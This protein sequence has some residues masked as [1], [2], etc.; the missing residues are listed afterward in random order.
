MLEKKKE[1]LWAGGRQRD[2]NSISLYSLGKTSCAQELLF[3]TS[4]ERGQ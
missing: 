4:R 2:F 3:F 1:F